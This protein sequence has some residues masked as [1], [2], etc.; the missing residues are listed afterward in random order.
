MSKKEEKARKYAESV[1][2]TEIEKQSE[3]QDAKIGEVIPEFDISHMKNAFE[4]GWHAAMEY[5]YRLPFDTMVE[6][7]I[8]EMKNK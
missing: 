3:L 8:K 2:N 1:F 5:I 4:S 7:V 6:E